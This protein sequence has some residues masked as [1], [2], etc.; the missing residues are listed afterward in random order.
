M[1]LEVFDVTSGEHP[2]INCIIEATKSSLLTSEFIN[3][4]FSLNGKHVRVRQL[5]DNRYYFYYMTS[6]KNDYSRLMFIWDNTQQDRIVINQA[7]LYWVKL[8]FT[9]F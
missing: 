5:S 1:T 7:N 9:T 8:I 4:D 2:Q 6:A 3:N